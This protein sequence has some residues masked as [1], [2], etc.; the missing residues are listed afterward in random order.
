M[1]NKIVLDI[2]GTVLIVAAVCYFFLIMFAIGMSDNPEASKE[3]GHQ[4]FWALP[5]VAIGLALV[6]RPWERHK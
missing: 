3:A 5:V 6:W 4:L 1:T 2:I